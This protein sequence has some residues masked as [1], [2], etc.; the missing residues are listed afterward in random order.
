M[1]DATVEILDRKGKARILQA[2]DLEGRVIACFTER[3]TRDGAGKGEWYVHANH[4]NVQRS[5]NRFNFY[6]YS[7][8][9]RARLAANRHLNIN[10]KVLP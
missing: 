2:I 4:V 6:V 5:R 1:T 7:A 10:R 3:R 8:T 9:H